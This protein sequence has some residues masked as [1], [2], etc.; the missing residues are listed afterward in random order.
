MEELYKS[1]SKIRTLC[2]L[3]AVANG[4]GLFCVLFYGIGNV[5]SFA[6]VF[7]MAIMFYI[8][9]GIYQACGRLVEEPLF[10]PVITIY[11]K[12]VCYA[13]VVS[14]VGSSIIS[15]IIDSVKIGGLSIT[16][17]LTMIGVGLL[18][19]IGA[20]IYEYGCAMKQ[21]NDLII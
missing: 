3:A 1:I 15:T 13:C 11:M 4:I 18:L 2:I 8:F 19:Y 9:I 7:Q 12:K 16:L 6:T 20:E 10:S 5:I 17:N 21:E 14:G